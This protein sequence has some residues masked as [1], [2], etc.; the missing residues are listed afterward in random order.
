MPCYGHSKR[1][2]R[3]GRLDVGGGDAE[4]ALASYTEYA[5]ALCCLP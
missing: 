3:D 5:A 1:V 4:K 2:M